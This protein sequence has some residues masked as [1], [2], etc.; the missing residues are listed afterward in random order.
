MSSQQTPSNDSNLN[1]QIILSSL[2]GSHKKV[3]ETQPT[4]FVRISPDI[5]TVAAHGCDDQP[6]K[7]PKSSHGWPEPAETSFF[8]L[9]PAMLG[10]WGTGP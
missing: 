4:D 1:S 3:M 8:P 5:D 10:L 6:Q 7:L 9:K 2:N